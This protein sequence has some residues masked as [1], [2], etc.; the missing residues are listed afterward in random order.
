[1][2]Y[3]GLQ[4]SWWQWRSLSVWSSG[5]L[6]P[7][8]LWSSC[9]SCGVREGLCKADITMIVRDED[10]STWPCG[11]PWGHTVSSS[12]ASPVPRP[13]P[14]QQQALEESMPRE[15]PGK[16][17]WSWS[18]KSFNNSPKV[19]QGQQVPGTV[20]EIR[21]S[22]SK[23]R[24]PENQSLQLHFSSLPFPPFPSALAPNSF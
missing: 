19:M 6:E 23:P 4:P 5:T 17:W 2:T 15:F 9:P 18:P 22:D 8:L 10:M 12:A 7:S 3:T 14:G 1:M 20:L 11:R 21:F 16:Q 13:V 24:V